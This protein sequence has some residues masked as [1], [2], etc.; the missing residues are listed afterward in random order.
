MVRIKDIAEKCGV[1]TATVSYVIHGKHEKV[2]KEVR[3][4]IEA[5]IENS[6]YISNQSAIN[7][8]SRS[9]GLIGV[10]VMNT[11]E[12]KNIMS[13][14]YFSI[15]FSYLESEFRKNDKYILILLNQS[16]E[17]LIRDCLRW[18]LD[19]LILC[20]YK[21]DN[22]IAISREFMKP[23]VTI[24]ASFNHNY[25]N[26]VQIFID[27]FDGGYQMGKYFM[28][29]GH[30]AVGMLDDNDYEPDRHRWRGFRQA[31]MDSGIKI[32]ESSHY[33]VLPDEIP[34]EDK[35]E[36]IYDEIRTKTAI[37]C[38]SD[39]YALQLIKFLN[40]KG[41]SVPKDISVSGY[42]DI[43]YSRLL[44]PELTTV[45]QDVEMKAIEAVSGMMA[46]LKKKEVNHSVKMKV[47][48]VVR[49]STKKFVN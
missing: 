6:G 15:M 40:K 13:D 28:K 5:E 48:L 7:L 32:D 21:K 26:L 14:P 37:F 42:D 1:S 29:L 31:C 8:V 44:S 35:L 12:E 30:K 9:S 38:Q 20:N 23:I 17:E 47:E 36:E 43:A 10:S 24:D 25:D 3:E 2:S 39:F 45:R 34:I 41:L 22:M 18:N 27:D 16:E 19:G 33:T 49:E 4:R 46:M 11:V